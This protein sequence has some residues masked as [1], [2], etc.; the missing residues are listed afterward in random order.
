MNFLFLNCA[1]FISSS[2]LSVL[3]LE[4]H[5]PRGSWDLINLFN[6]ATF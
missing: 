1:G 3:A 6:L 4:I 5:F 2:V